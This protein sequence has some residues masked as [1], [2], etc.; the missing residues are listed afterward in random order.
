MCPPYSG[1][2]QPYQDPQTSSMQW[3]NG[4]QLSHPQICSMQES[5]GQQHNYPQIYG[6]Q[7]DNG[8]QRNPFQTSGIQQNNDSLHS[9]S[10]ISVMQSDNRSSQVSVSRPHLRRP[11]EERSTAAAPNN[12]SWVTPETG[13]FNQSGTPKSEAQVTIP[14]STTS[15]TPNMTTTFSEVPQR[16]APSPSHLSSNISQPASGLPSSIPQ[17]S[18]TEYP[19]NTVENARGYVTSLLQ[20]PLQDL[21]QVPYEQHQR[22]LRQRMED[23]QR[24]QSSTS[25]FPESEE[26]NGPNLGE[27]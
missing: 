2:L 8:Y 3:N 24:Q 19:L 18:I 15:S 20:T 9:H 14:Y 7:S 1:Y 6:M 25:Q 22:I 5:I 23:M 17:A 21:V 12:E 4:S 10:K 26:R 27:S 13:S 16:T 11:S